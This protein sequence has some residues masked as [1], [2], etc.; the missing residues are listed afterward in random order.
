MLSI[1]PVIARAYRG[2]MLAG[3]TVGELVA[4]VEPGDLVAVPP[5]YSGV[6][7]AATR[8][9]IAAGLRPLRLVAVPTSGMQADMLVGAGLVSEL[10][11]AAVMLGEFGTASRFVD[12]LGADALRMRDATCPAIHAGLQAGEKGV[13]FLPLRG[14]L[15]SD[16]L[17]LRPDW[18]TIPN[19][20]EP[21]DRI[22]LVPAIRPDVAL[23]HAPRA[24]RDGN[25]WVGRRRELVTMA[26]ASRRTLVTVEEV[27]DDS[28]LDDE[29]SA[30]GVLPALY[31]TAVATAPNGAWPLGLPGVYQP[32]QAELARYAE[33]SRTADGFREYVGRT[34]LH[35]R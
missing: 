29:V 27:V 1:T 11:A 2:R 30:A 8:A 32:D 24:D 31:V 5:D 9:L 20:Y 35:A 12:A 19:P 3:V 15:G 33:A 16:L 25:V 7:M 17:A 14:L 23:F 10:E 26:H 21:G 6:S 13:P 18:Q 4:H 22:V 28:L 34:P